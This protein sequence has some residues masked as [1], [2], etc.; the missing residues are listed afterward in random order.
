MKYCQCC[1]QP[2]TRPN[3]QFTDEGICPACNYFQQLKDVDWQER[4][5]ILN[6]LLKQFPRQS[7]PYFDCILGVSG[8]KD[9]SR[10]AVDVRV[11]FGLNTL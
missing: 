7:G 8:G 11:K 4:Y 5:E 1:L 3:S 6:D 2:D 9:S 10:Q